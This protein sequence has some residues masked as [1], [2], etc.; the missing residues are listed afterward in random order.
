MIKIH[1]S[2]QFP[3]Q[4]YYIWDDVVHD[5]STS[6]ITTITGHVSKT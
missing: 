1:V 6:T 5:P 4:T 3:A 2:S